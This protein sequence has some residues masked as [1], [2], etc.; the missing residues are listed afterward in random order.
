[1]VHKT[2]KNKTSTTI[3]DGNQEHYNSFEAE[4]SPIVSKEQQCN[5][6]TYTTDGSTF[7]EMSAFENPNATGLMVGN[8]KYVSLYFFN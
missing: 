2:P 8:V 5:K 6:T 4:P 3:S 1:M 7:D